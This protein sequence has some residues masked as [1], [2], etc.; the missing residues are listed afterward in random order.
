[1][2]DFWTTFLYIV[3]MI[4]VIVG[5]YLATKFIAGKGGRAVVIPLGEEARPHG[6]GQGQ[7]YHIG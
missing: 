1:M 5:A 7:A 4:A 3:V 2:G 6:A